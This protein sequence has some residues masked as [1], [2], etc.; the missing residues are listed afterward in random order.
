MAAGWLWS[1]LLDA[2]GTPLFG[3]SFLQRRLQESRILAPGRRQNS[4]PRWNLWAQMVHR[5]PNRG[6]RTAVLVRVFPRLQL[7]E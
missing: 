5:A 1:M 7:A 4:F 3:L 2:N 6:A